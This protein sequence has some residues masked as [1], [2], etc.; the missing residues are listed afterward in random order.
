MD[1]VDSQIHVNQLGINWHDADPDTVIE[2]A[3]LMMDA[4]GIAAV[5]IDEA[6]GFDDKHRHLPS[7]EL[8]NGAIRSLYPVGDR[9]VARFP[10]RFGLIARVD[11]DDPELDAVM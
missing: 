1:I 4:V 5:L 8:S 10:D 7:Y 6:A 3:I 11:P 9:A 2:T